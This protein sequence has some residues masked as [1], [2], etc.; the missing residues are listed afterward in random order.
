MHDPDLKSIDPTLCI[1]LSA[2]E[3]FEKSFG[4]ENASGSFHNSNIANSVH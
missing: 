4:S 3:N 2:K 1:S